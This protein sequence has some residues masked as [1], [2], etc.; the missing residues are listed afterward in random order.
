M[1]LNSAP[2]SLALV[3]LDPA[4]GRWLGGGLCCGR[5]GCC[6]CGFGAPAVFTLAL[7]VAL[8]LVA[9]AH[10]HLGGEHYTG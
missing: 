1:P 9:D 8:L 10:V 4:R 7:L 5:G 6:G 3:A 2:C